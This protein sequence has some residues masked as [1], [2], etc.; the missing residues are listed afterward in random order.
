MVVLG[1]VSISFVWTSV[2][3]NINPYYVKTNN[4]AGWSFYVGANYEENGKWSLKDN[5]VFF[6]EVLPSVDSDVTAAQDEIFSR[7]GERYFEMMTN[8]KLVDHMFN[9][10]SV[11]FADVDNSIYD[12]RYD[13]HIKKETKAMICYRV[14]QNIILLFYFSLVIVTC[15]FIYW[16]YKN[17]IDKYFDNNRMML[18]IVIT[19]VGLFAASTLVEVMNRYSL[20]FITL[21]V[22]VAV[23]ALWDMKKCYNKV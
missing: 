1:Y 9:K 11:L 20:P 10:L 17:K 3:P 21:I 19:F 8:G 13:F 5:S 12:F 23:C 2:I 6:G 4:G 15:Y 7:G 14:I 18:Y 22:I 16:I